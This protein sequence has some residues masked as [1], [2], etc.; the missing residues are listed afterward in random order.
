[1]TDIGSMHLINYYRFAS[2]PF[3]CVLLIKRIVFGRHDNAAAGVAD[4]I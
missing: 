3:Y 4:H 2:L 1:M